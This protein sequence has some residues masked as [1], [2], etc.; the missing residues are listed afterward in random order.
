MCRRLL[1]FNCVNFRGLC[2]QAQSWPWPS[3][4]LMGPHEQQSGLKLSFKPGSQEA[5]AEPR[6]SPLPSGDRAATLPHGSQGRHP[7]QPPRSQQRPR[8]EP[9]PQSH[10]TGTSPHSLLHSCWAAGGGWWTRADGHRLGAGLC[11][12]QLRPSQSLRL[13]KATGIILFCCE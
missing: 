11:L 7:L 10:L 12:A 13:L 5:R 9:R 6:L 8:G 3:C 2:K 1:A 4:Y